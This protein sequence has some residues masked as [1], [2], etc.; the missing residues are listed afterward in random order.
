MPRIRVEINEY[1]KLLFTILIHGTF[2]FKLWNIREE[3]REIM[4]GHD[5]TSCYKPMY[6]FGRRGKAVSR[7]AGS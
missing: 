2:Q 6:F 5:F 1:N 3:P 4:T 7:S